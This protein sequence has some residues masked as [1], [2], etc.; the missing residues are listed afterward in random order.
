MLLRVIPAIIRLH[1]TGEWGRAIVSC[2]LVLGYEFE[3][4]VR[5]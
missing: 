5:P 2:A 1:A 4:I 3:D